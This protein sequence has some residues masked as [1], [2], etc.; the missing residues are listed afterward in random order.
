MSH[1]LPNTHRMIFSKPNQIHQYTWKLLP[2]RYMI[3]LVMMTFSGS[4]LEKASKEYSILRDLDTLHR[5]QSTKHGYSLT[6]YSSQTKKVTSNNIEI[7]TGAKLI[8]MISVLTSSLLTFN[9]FNN[10]KLISPSPGNTSLYQTLTR[11]SIWELMSILVL[12]INNKLLSQPLKKL[13]HGPT[14]HTNLTV[15]VL[16]NLSYKL[17]LV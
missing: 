2:P 15:T 10:S 14:V 12:L 4:N 6:C 5:V 8:N 1:H 17:G 7:T 13:K 3:K 16:R 11:N 9:K